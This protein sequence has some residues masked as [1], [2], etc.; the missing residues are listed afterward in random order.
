MI[1]RTASGKVAYS[2]EAAVLILMAM[3]TVFVFSAG[4]DVSSS[5]DFHHFYE[6]TT[7]KQLLFFPLAVMIM[8]IASRVD[9]RRFSFSRGGPF[10]SFSAWMLGIAVLLLVAVLLFGV[11]KNG[12]RRWLLIRLGPATVSFQ[13]SELAKWS[14]IFFLAA[15]LDYFADTIK[16]FWKRFVPVCLVAGVVVGLIVGQDFGT[17][18]FIAMLTFM[19]LLIGGAS[20]WHFFVPVAAAAPAFFVAVYSSPYRLDR[21]KAFF[22]PDKVSP[23]IRYQADQ[24]LIAIS[25]GRMWGKG[26]GM[27]VSKYRHLPED[28]TDFIFSIICEESG[29][30]GGLFVILLFASLVVMG[31]VVAA[32][33]RDRF[34]RLLAAGIALTI[35]IQAAINIGVVTV[36]LPTKGIPLPFISAGGTSMLLCAAAAGVLVNIARQTA[37]VPQQL[38]RELIR[39][40]TQAAEN[41]TQLPSLH[42]PI[43]SRRQVSATGKSARRIHP[44]HAFGRDR[45]HTVIPTATASTRPPA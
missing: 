6:F 17:A 29:F 20:W 1:G 25:S 22:D 14:M 30:A 44:V 28:T 7:L 24:S 15:F 21:I 36:V 9:H 5:Y 34:S 45:A 11:E 35:G 26:L 18:A 41:E 43:R 40:V 38:R 33:C 39:S 8:L 42:S 3:G 27:G 19:M 37:D 13:P 23:D 10:K 2:I 12:S 32:R 16:R 31:L 4:A